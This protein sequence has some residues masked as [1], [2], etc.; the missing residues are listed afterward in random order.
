M[1]FTTLYNFTDADGYSYQILYDNVSELVQTVTNDPLPDPYVTE[2]ELGVSNDHTFLSYCKGTTLV[3]VQSTV[4]YPF[5]VVR[6][7][8]NSP[9]CSVTQNCTIHVSDVEIEN[10]TYAGYNDGSAAILIDNNSCTDVV[11]S[12]DNVNW[13]AENIFH[14]LAPGNYLGYAKCVNACYNFKAFSVDAGVP[15]PEDLLPGGE[16]PWYEKI[17]KW[18]K[19]IVNGVTTVTSEPIKWD[20]VNIKGLR[21]PVWHGFNYMFSDGIIELEFDCPAGKE[22]IEAEYEV[23]GNDGEVFFQHGFTYKGTEFLLFDGKLN[24][25]TYKRYPGKVTASVEK[26][27]FNTLLTSRFETKV[28]MTDDITIDGELVIPPMPV[29]FTLHA[30]EI[31]R[32]YSIVNNTVETSQQYAVAPDITVYIHPDTLTPQLSEIEDYFGYQLQISTEVPYN[33][34]LF[35]WQAKFGGTY[36]FIVNY[37]IDLQMQAQLQNGTYNLQSF[38]RVNTTEYIVGPFRNGSLFHDA[39]PTIENINFSF[40]QVINLVP[41][42]KVYFYSRLNLAK[43]H[44]LPP[45]VII[46]LVQNSISIS[47]AALERTAPTPAKGWWLFDSIDHVTR[48]IT[49]R[50]ARLKSSFLGFRG[51]FQASDGMGALFTTTNGKQIRRFDVDTNPLNI[52]L[53]DLLESV[54]AIFCIGYGIEKK[55]S[56]QFVTVERVNYFYRNKRDLNHRGSRRIS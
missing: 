55:G 35:D 28:S 21:D 25:N 46:K 37:N 8:D 54:R 7:E 2:L 40:T 14:G 10:E 36:T 32:K 41:G 22:I 20:N 15:R 53:K 13:Q 49:N 9:T 33:V 50:S 6:Y 47:V 30:K 27:D 45:A 31:I 43:S 48:S 24:L 16:Y 39:T 23:H 11:Y 52:A 56:Q 38:F 26:A 4:N 12:L 19:L 18:F 17:C 1:A 42:D 44:P 34:D 29:N 51:A 3:S 5:A